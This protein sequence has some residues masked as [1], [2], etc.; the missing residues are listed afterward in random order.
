MSVAFWRWG[1][2]GADILVAA[3]SVAATVLMRPASGWW[4]WCLAALVGLPLAVRRLWPVPVL[5]LVALAGGASLVVGLR[6]EVVVYAVAFALYP[7][8]L[9]P[10]RAAGWGLIGALSAVLVPGLTDA[11]IAGL[12]LVSARD[13]QESFSTEPATVATFSVAIIVGPWALGWAVRTRHRYIGRLTEMHTAR[14]VAE[15]R[16]RIARDVHDVVGHTLSLIA[17]KAAVATHLGAEQDAAL[18]TIEKVSRTALD[19]VRTVLSG[20]RDES[21]SGT[22]DGPPTMA[23]VDRLVEEVR[24]TGVT[25]ELDQPDLTSVPAGVQASAFRI[26][27]EA[28]TNVRRHA[29]AT[30]CWIALTVASDVLR[31]T[32]IDNGTTSRRE[33]PPGNGLL[34]MRE[35]AAVHGGS[36]TAGPEPNGGFAVRAELPLAK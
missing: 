24:A 26:V 36:L 22:T 31:L 8:A 2:I 12:P 20:L 34:G 9:L 10:V 13:D 29:G 30:H 32:I 33:H 11:V 17:M 1:L 3:A 7:V 4:V 16:L 21:G 14:M 35:R 6:G 25:I 18:Q 15:E 28:L 19:D 5:V 23:T 27:Q